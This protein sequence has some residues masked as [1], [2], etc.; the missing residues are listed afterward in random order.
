MNRFYTHF[1]PV[2]APL[3]KV[4]KHLAGV[5]LPS[6]CVSCEQVMETDEGLVFCPPCY[7]D[8]PFW[9]KTETPEPKLHE[10]IE[11]FSAPLLYKDV[12]S[13]LVRQFKYGDLT[14]LKKPLIKLMIN[15]CPNFDSPPVVMPVPMHGKRLAKRGYNQAAILARGLS[16]SK[17]WFYDDKSL[18][19]I[20]HTRTQAG[21]SA[22]GRKR[23]LQ[24]AFYVQ[25]EK[26]S[27]EKI[28]LVDDVLTTGTTVEMCAKKLKRAGAK[29]VHVLTLCY[30]PLSE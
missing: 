23:N 7:R 15:A 26:V 8:L 6:V 13:E 1:N 22:E 18:S 24:G 20:K 5:L 9:D 2:I 25:E 19:R 14:E 30:V 10:A 11:S 29:E 16:K 27:G 17:G 12:A 3:K 28:L 21:Q 4:G